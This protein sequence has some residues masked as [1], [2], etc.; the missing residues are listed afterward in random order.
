M[1]FGQRVRFTAKELGVMRTGSS[2]FIEGESVNAG[3]EGMY[4][5]PMPEEGWHLID[6]GRDRVV[7]ASSHM[8]EEVSD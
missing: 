5:G 1:I 7:L 2:K 6:V 4:V 8:F 3:D